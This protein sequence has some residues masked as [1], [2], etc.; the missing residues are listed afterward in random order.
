MKENNQHSG[1]R[2]IFFLAVFAR[3][4][5][6]GGADDF[7]N[8]AAS[9]QVPPVA[10]ETA[11]DFYNAGTRQFRAGKLNDAESLF[12][13]SIAKQDEST[14]SAS[15]YNLGHVRFAQGLEELKKAAS[16][17][18]AASRSR[19][20]VGV[21]AGA[22]Q[23]AESALAGNDIR[24]MV[25]AYMDGRG[26]RKELRAATEAVRRAMEAHGKTLLKWRRAL[27]DFKS[28]AELNPADTNAARNAEIVAQSIAKLVDSLREMQQMAMAMAAGQ[29]KL[30]ESLQQL[31][32][33][34][35]APN[36]PP[37]A[38][39]EDGE[40]E[41]PMDSLKG[42]KEQGQTEE[43][44][45]MGMSLSPDEAARLLDGIQSDGKLL[46]MGQGDQGKPRDRKGKTW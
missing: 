7:T 20:A 32:G 2:L 19:Q 13:S 16:P 11:R 17:K 30:N 23:E 12:Q 3:A 40:E 21:A 27:G 10:M 15:L 25:E 38:P 42:L 37:G 18:A 45:E 34:I 14:Q 8:T 46:P 39:G 33:R 43:G 6:V 36:M 4:L 1:A 24:Q 9:L 31:K 26:A 41:M 5:A 22:I 28:A 35:P 44:K 29:A